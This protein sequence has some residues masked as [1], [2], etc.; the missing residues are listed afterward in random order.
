MKP[1]ILIIIFLLSTAKIFGQNY[2]PIKPD[3]ISEKSYN[4]Y[5]SELDKAYEKNDLWNVGVNIA[6]MGEKP[7]KVFKILNDAIK[8][9]PKK[10]CFI[11]HQFGH[12][13]INQE[14]PPMVTTLDGLDEK[15][16]FKMRETCKML[17]DSVEFMKIYQDL[18]NR[19]NKRYSQI[20]SSKLDFDLIKKLEVI[21]EKDKRYRVQIRMSTDSNTEKELWRKQNILDKENISEIELIIK[22]RGLP[23]ISEVGRLNFIPWL[24]LHHCTDI[25]KKEK[26]LPLLEQQVSTGDLSK[27]NLEIYKVRL[28]L[29][30]A[31]K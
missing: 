27:S 17:M 2:Y 12:T 9:N 15:E 31:G 22:E 24:V 14:A 7:K 18:V 6:N 30:H 23:S 25:K 28:K 26:Y 11:V 20:D 10:C 19:N 3:S 5:K 4:H 8:E 1:E 13:Y 16:V 21:F 29:Y